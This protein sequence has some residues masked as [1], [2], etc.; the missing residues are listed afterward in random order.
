[1]S[2]F[3][4]IAVWT[5]LFITLY[6]FLFTL[7]SSPFLS[8]SYILLLQ[9]SNYF[10][11]IYQIMTTYH[12]TSH[13][14]RNQVSGLPVV[15]TYSLATIITTA[16]YLS[17]TRMQCIAPPFAFNSTSNSQFNCTSYNNYLVI[18]CSQADIAQG[19]I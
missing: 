13:R 1:M 3:V 17:K 11:L 19:T 12:I 16:Q 7:F 14:C 6:H 18:K 2:L 10:V 4:M 8:Y 9:Q 5:T 15:G